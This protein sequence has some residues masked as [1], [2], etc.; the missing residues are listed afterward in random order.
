MHKIS[1]TVSPVQVGNIPADRHACPL[2]VRPALHWHR[3]ETQFALSDIDLWSFVESQSLTNALL[4]HC[5]LLPDRDRV[6]AL[7]RNG[8]LRIWKNMSNGKF[9]SVAWW[10]G[11]QY[12]YDWLGNFL[13]K[14]RQYEHDETNKANWGDLRIH[15]TWYA[16]HCPLFP[17]WQIPLR[18]WLL[19]A[20]C[21]EVWDGEDGLL[22]KLS[23]GA[24]HH[25]WQKLPGCVAVMH[26]SFTS[27]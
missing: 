5:A 14:T 24:R 25:T 2:N 20:H 11:C 7:T 13:T 17:V 6:E 1:Y 10:L 16:L 3:F 21:W 18:H 26:W 12:S 19:L 27:T 23:D 9:T 22:S 8:H 4:L 15:L